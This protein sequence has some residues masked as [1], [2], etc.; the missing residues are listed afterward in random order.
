MNIMRYLWIN[1]C[2]FAALLLSVAECAAESEFNTSFFHG[3]DKETINDIID[4]D[5]GILPGSYKVDVYVNHLLVEQRDIEFLRDEKSGR[6]QPCLGSVQLKAWAVN[7]DEKVSDAC[8]DIAQRFP[9]ASVQ[10]DMTIH[11]LDIQVP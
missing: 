6:M 3:L 4:P 2:G 11:R 9:G 7:L 5:S 1:S 10:Y 8:F